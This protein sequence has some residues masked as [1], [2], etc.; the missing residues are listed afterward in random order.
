M[1]A[2]QVLWE[3]SPSLCSLTG[4]QRKSPWETRVISPCKAPQ[5]SGKKQIPSQPH[6][7]RCHLSPLS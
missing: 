3:L 7:V 2:F 1:G 4:H 5:S 6:K